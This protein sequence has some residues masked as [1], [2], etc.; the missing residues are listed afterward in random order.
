MEREE[1][2]AEVL[3]RSIESIRREQYVAE[4]RSSQ[5][6][7]PFREIAREQYKLMIE[8]IYVQAEEQTN[9]F[10]LNQQG[11]AAGIDPMSL[12]SGPRSRVEKYASEELKRFFDASGRQ[13]FED[14]IAEIEAGQPTGEVGRD[15]NR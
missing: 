15:F 8:R 10:M 14:F 5:D 1:A 12:F 9:G 11:E 2:A 6:R 4:H 13:T 3:G 7:R